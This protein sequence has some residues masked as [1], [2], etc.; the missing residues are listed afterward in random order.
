MVPLSLIL[1]KK[2]FYSLGLILLY[3]AT[4][5]QRI[6]SGP[7]PGYTTMTESSIWLQ[8]N[9]PS[10][11]SLH[12]WETD[13]SDSVL[14]ALSIET[15]DRSANT[16]KF[17]ISNLQPGTTYG[18]EIF[19]DGAAQKLDRALTFQTQVLWQFRS[20]PP[21]FSVAL[22]SC[23]YVNEKAFDR[24][25]KVY[26]GSY[27]IFDQIAATKP[28]MMLWLGD[29]I[30]LR[31]TDWTSRSGYLH[32]Y[33]HT[34][35]LPELQRLL[36]STHHY[37]IWDDHDFGPNDANGSWMH[38][39]WALEMFEMFWANPSTGIPGQIGITSAF[40]FNDMDFVLLDNR[41]HR[42]SDNL[43]RGQTQILGKD[44]I[45]WLIEI[46]KF[47]RAPFK[48]VAVG[49][50]VLNPA[51]VYET[52]AVYG[53]E[54]QY[55]LDRIDEEQIKGVV[56][57]TG[58]RHHTELS[59]IVTENGIEIYDL[60][61]SPLTAGTHVA[62]DERNTLRMENTLVNERNFAVLSFSGKRRDRSMKISIF[63]QSGTLQW[64]KDIAANP[65]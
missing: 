60:T 58:D 23:A 46:L 6:V 16:A 4:F 21:D 51:A 53:E 7:M 31:E 62:D 56:F 14:T 55:L 9:S 20:D 38:K 15:A 19:V 48:F 2:I 45:D 11:V 22:G 61:V 43:K 63:D 33:S 36:S 17:I 29:N 35:S 57:L 59:K 13:N 40:Q 64:E 49:G 5:G 39:D 18:Y 12:F 37:A 24:P 47:S 10:V 3:G 44:Q 25:N 30:Y 1:M 50:Q 34:R 54:R 27:E 52:Y 26:G 32:R 42:S 65:N 8:V 28:N 41:Y